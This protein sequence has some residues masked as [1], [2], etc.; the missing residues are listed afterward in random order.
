MVTEHEIL[1]KS[2]TDQII[3]GVPEGVLVGTIDVATMT[4]LSGAPAS[5]DAIT[6]QGVATVTIVVESPTVFDVSSWT[7]ALNEI[8]GFMEATF[9]TETLGENDELL[10]IYEVSATVQVDTSV[11]ANRFSEEGAG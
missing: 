5:P 6:D 10:P 8:P 11:F 4:P 7:D 9:S 2:L 3:L 1:W